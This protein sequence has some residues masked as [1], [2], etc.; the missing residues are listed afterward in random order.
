MRKRTTS[1]SRL[2]QKT[3]LKGGGTLKIIPL[4]GLEEVGRNMT[5]LEYENQILIVDMGLQF[6]D[7]NTP[8]IDFIIPNI[9]YLTTHPEKKILGV[10]ITHAHYDHI[11]CLLYTSPSPRD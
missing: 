9:E 3:T 8:G 2:L 6:P 4:G 10:F 7:E 11:G 1:R 5:L